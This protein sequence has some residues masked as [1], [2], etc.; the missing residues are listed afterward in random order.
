[1]STE[2]PPGATGTQRS[3][4]PRLPPR[5]GLNAVFLMPGL[6]GLDTYVRELVPELLALAPEVRFSVFTTPVGESHLAGMDWADEVEFVTH[7]LLGPRGLK[8]A[9]ELTLLGV[10]AGRRVDLLHS[11]AFTAPLRTR[12]VNVVMIP[13]ITWILEP[14]PD[15]SMRLWR[16]IVPPVARRADRVIAISRSGAEH[17]ERY[18]RVPAERIDV[19]LLGY[20]PQAS[21]APMEERRLREQLG[22]G[23]RELVLAVAT[24]RPHKN[25]MRLIEAMPAVLQARP[26]AALVLC[27][28]P[29]P[30]DRELAAAVERLGLEGRVHLLSFVDADVLEGLYAAAA[31]FVMPSLNEGFGLPVLEAM[32]RGVPVASSNASA[33]PEVGGDAARYFDPLDVADMA[34]TIVE[35][36]TDPALSQELVAAGR[37]QAAS[38]TWKRTAERTL[39]SYERAWHA[40]R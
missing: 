26:Q 35:I 9:T 2:V 33:L 21:A 16:V 13:D 36:L 25:L 11:I 3:G 7:P 37:K 12:A 10:L 23:D 8:A 30:H 19:T 24:R 40:R 27:G 28:N 18:L 20:S 32:G 15:P 39:E 5:V 34:R 38:M 6:G 1:V 29:T 22:L 31:C 17:I 14:H 4:R